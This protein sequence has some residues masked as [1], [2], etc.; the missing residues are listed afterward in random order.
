MTC[1]EISSAESCLAWRILDL[2]RWAPSG[3]NLQPWRFKLLGPTEFVVIPQIPLPGL[4]HDDDA[5]ITGLS[6]GALLETISLAAM[7]FGA[8]ADF[9]QQHDDD[10]KATWHVK[11]RRRQDVV[12]SRLGDAIQIRSVHGGPLSTQR[13][14]KDE[15]GLLQA[16]LGEGYTLRWFEGAASRW[17]V[18]RLLFSAAKVRLMMPEARLAH[19]EIIG[20]RTRYSTAR[21]PAAALGISR[22]TRF[23]MPWVLK[24]RARVDFLNRYLAGTWLP[25]LEMEVRAGLMCGAHFAVTA[26]HAVESAAERAAAGR[27]MQRFWLTATTLGLQL[28]FGVRAGGLCAICPT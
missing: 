10:A 13:L 1:A 24:K 8:S 9:R 25:R 11:L 6:I 26:A 28:Q 2:A 20:W 22:L 3:D 19:N 15:K 4:R 5:F 27:A 18:T 21:I 16:S 14:T 23:F 7:E 17:R 12:R